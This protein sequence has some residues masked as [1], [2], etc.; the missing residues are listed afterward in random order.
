[1]FSRG[2]NGSWGILAATGGIPPASPDLS[3]VSGFGQATVTIANSTTGSFNAIY[4]KEVDDPLWPE[5]ANTTIV[6]DG[7]AVIVLDPG[8]YF[9]KVVSAKSGLESPGA[10]DPVPFS[11]IGLDMPDLSFVS[12]FDQAIA[13]IANSTI[14]SSNAIYIKEVDGSWPEVANATIA[15]DGSAVIVLDSGDYLGKV[16]S[17]KSSAHQGGAL[18]P[19]SFPV[20]NDEEGLTNEN[21]YYLYLEDG[22]GGTVTIPPETKVELP[23]YFLKYQD[24]FVRDDTP[25]VVPTDAISLGTPVLVYANSSL[26]EE[27]GTVIDKDTYNYQ[28][29]F[30]TERC[31]WFPFSE[32][33]PA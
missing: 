21:W 16:V 18:D 29:E 17:T 4:V 15:G 9:G 23:E 5:T 3:F 26:N 12:G 27:T 8:D 10:L 19:V 1:M 2:I 32:V 30:G 11:V 28:I 31:V 13:T 6:G 22:D 24:H 20:F 14:G 33:R 7:S 25:G